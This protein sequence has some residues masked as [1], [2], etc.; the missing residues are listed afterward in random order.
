[1]PISQTELVTTEVTDH[2][3]KVAAAADRCLQVH[4]A[5]DDFL[6]NTAASYAGHSSSGLYVDTVVHSSSHTPTYRNVNSR[7]PVSQNEFPGMTR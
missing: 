6:Q 7:S 1:M 4:R 3:L 2:L 5:I